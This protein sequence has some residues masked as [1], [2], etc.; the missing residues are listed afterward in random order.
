MQQDAAWNKKKKKGVRRIVMKKATPK[1]RSRPEFELI[2][3]GRT[4]WGVG[5]I[6]QPGAPRSCRVM[7]GNVELWV[8]CEMLCILRSCKLKG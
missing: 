2:K 7:W 8:S 4:D 5:C 1:A 6:R 3:D